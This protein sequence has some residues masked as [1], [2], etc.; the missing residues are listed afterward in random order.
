MNAI[1]FLENVIGPREIG[2]SRLLEGLGIGTVPAHAVV[3]ARA[4]GREAF[5]LRV[6]HAVDEAHELAGDVAVKPW[7]SKRVLSE[8]RMRGGKITK[9]TLPTP[10]VSETR[11][12]APG[13]S[14]DPDGS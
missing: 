5:A 12:A 11:C 6:V 13:R 2:V 7:R 1:V 14:T 8:A 10:A 9:S 3:Q 4:A